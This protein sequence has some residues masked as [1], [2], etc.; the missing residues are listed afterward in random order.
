[1][2][3]IDKLTNETLEEFKCIDIDKDLIPYSFTYDHN[4]KIFYM[5]VFYNSKYDYFTIDLYLME[6]EKKIPLIFGEK[7]M[8]GQMLFQ[9]IA[10]RNIDIPMIIPWDFSMKSKRAGFDEMNSIYLALIDESEGE[11]DIL[12]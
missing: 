1:M 9:S 7:I 2:I 5:E 6:N 8:I 12:G 11:D 4:R 3:D 10:Y